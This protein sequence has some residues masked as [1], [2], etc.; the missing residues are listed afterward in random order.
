ME[1]PRSIV[2]KLNQRDARSNNS[3]DSDDESLEK[4]HHRRESVVNIDSG[5]SESGSESEAESE[6]ESDKECNR[7]TIGDVAGEHRDENADSKPF[8]LIDCPGLEL[9]DG[10]A[11]RI[12]LLPISIVLRS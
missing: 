3:T 5:R 9:T 10:K 6:A 2:P 7:Q 11:L 8:D 12:S 1:W 4:G